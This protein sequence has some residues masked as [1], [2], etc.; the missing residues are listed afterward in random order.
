MISDEG[1][2]EIWGMSD[3]EVNALPRTSVKMIRRGVSGRDIHTR[4]VPFTSRFSP[5]KALEFDDETTII[6]A[7]GSERNFIVYPDGSV[8]YFPYHS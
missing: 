2:M 6:T 8:E 1:I 4:P 5:L 7:R 3:D